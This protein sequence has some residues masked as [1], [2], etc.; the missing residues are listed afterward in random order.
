MTTALATNTPPDV[1]EIGNTNVPL[2]AASGALANLN[3][4]KSKL[5]GGSTFV[6]SLAGPAMVNGQLYAAPFY[7]GARAVIYNKATWANA[8]VTAPPKTFAEF[9]SDLGK[10]AAHNKTP[11]FSPIY[12]SGTYWYGGF[13]FVTDAGG[14][15]ATEKNGQWTSGLTSAAAIK[16]LKEFKAFQNKYS[17]VASRTAPLDT[18]DPN[19]VFGTG[20]TATILGNANSLTTIVTTYPKLKGQVSSFVFPSPNHS[21]EAA[22]T[23]VGGSDLGVAAKSNNK[24]LAIKFIEMIDSPSVQLQQLTTA[25]GHT[26]VT[27]KLI[28]QASKNVDP[29]VQAFFESASKS[30]PTPASPGWA[31]IETDQTV[32]SYFSQAAA[33]TSTPQQSASKFAS[34]LTQ[35]LNSN[36]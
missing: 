11:D 23:F 34:H 4:E 18:P 21:G 35:A 16:G 17:T 9:E 2:Y 12:V 25:D 28:Q 8:G 33:G 3:S 24:S 5:D 1:V 36:K 29:S 19:A 22:P 7:G 14:T 10:V 32:L 26:P 6:T 15:I 13:S 30:Y 20:K 31:T 27:D